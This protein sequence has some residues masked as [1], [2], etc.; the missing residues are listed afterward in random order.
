MTVSGRTRLTQQD[1][2]F[3]LNICK[4]KPLINTLVIQCKALDSTQEVCYSFL[5]YRVQH[6]SAEVGDV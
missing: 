1:I 4:S 5:V 3:L 2:L 6:T